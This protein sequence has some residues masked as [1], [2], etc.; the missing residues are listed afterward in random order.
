MAHLLITVIFDLFLDFNSHIQ[1]SQYAGLIEDRASVSEISQR[2]HVQEVIKELYA[3]LRRFIQQGFQRANL[4]VHEHVS[5]ISNY[6][7][8]NRTL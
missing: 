8:G 6:I 4:T 1:I 3:Q 5:Y 2:L 7:S